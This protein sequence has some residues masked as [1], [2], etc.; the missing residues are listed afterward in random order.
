VL[1]LFAGVLLREGPVTIG[2]IFEMF[3]SIIKKPLHRPRGLLLIF[4]QQLW[5][6]DAL[7][8]DLIG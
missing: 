1:E 8:E 6:A 5:L 2:Q 3:G 4:R 7:D